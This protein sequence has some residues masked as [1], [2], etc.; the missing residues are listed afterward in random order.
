MTK[1]RTSSQRFPE[2]VKSKLKMFL[3][4]NWVG[5]TPEELAG[6]WN[7]Q[8]AHLVDE[9]GIKDVLGHMGIMVS[10]EEIDRIKELK[11]KELEI[12]CSGS[13][14][15]MEKIRAERVDLMRKRL[16]EMKDIWTGLESEELDEMVA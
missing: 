7:I 9:D 3:G 12:I 1:K 4:N 2:D 13:S 11:K 16:E 14:S 10:E 8:S 15:I 6:A 5:N